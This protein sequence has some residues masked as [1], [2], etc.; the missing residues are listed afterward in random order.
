MADR[1][2]RAL[3]RLLPRE[4]RDAYARDMEVT[5]RRERIDAGAQWTRL[6]RLWLATIAD[7]ARSAPGHH[8]DLLR[9]DVRIAWRMLIARPLHLVAAAGALALGVGA[10]VAMFA[11]VDAVLLRPLPY[12]DAH[13]LLIVQETSRGGEPSNLGYL[14]FTDLKDRARTVRHLSAATQS[15]GTLTGPEADPERVPIM[16]ASAS[17]FDLVGAR[18][19]IGR[20]FT[21]AEDKPGAARRVAILSDRLWR[22][23]FNADPDIINRTI[24]ISGT[25]F[26]VVGVLPADFDDLVAARLYQEAEMWTPL[27]YDPAASFA[28]R[29]CRHLRVFARLDSQATPETAARELS[30]IISASAAANPTQY[31]RPGIV[32]TTLNEFFLGPV[33]P[34]L[35]I[36][37]GGV[38]LLLLVACG[39]VAN[40]LLIRATER[41]AEMAVRTALGVTPGRLFRQLLT[42]SWLL[43]LIGV[44]AGLPL[45]V[46]AIEF[47]VSSAPPQFPRLA[48]ASLDWRAAGVAAVLALATGALFG[49]VPAFQLSRPRLFSHLRDGG[50]RTAGVGTWRVRAAL[51]AGNMAMASALVASGGLVARSVM[52]L[53]AVDTGIR[54]DGVVTARIA[55]SGAHYSAGE[56][57]EQ[58]AK[59][60]AFYDAVLARV[61][62][63]PGVTNAAGVT[64]LPL[65]GSLD[66]YGLHIVGQELP[67]PEAAP[68]AHRFV[69]TPGFFETLQIPAVRGRLLTGDDRQNAPPVAVV[70]ETLARELFP[71][72]DAI[73]RQV[74]LGGADSP[75]RT[76][77]GIAA[78]IRHLGLDVPGGYQVYVPQAQWAWAETLIALVVRTDRDVTAAGG[79]IRDIV[80]QIDPAQPVTGIRAYS[81]IVR[82][83]TSAR[84]LAAA[85]LAGFAGVATLLAAIG[86]YGALGVVVGQRT[87]EIGLRLALGADARRIGALLMAQGL[88]P[89]LVGLAAGLAI[90]AM[91]GGVLRSLLYD[92][93]PVD[94][95]T[96]AVAALALAVCAAIAC[97]IPAWRATRVNPVTA[98]RSET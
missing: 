86:L 39:N 50:R 79:A 68:S 77:V 51:V 47:V 67:N 81:D 97:A 8:W 23:R 45:A 92:I 33:R 63:V 64:T 40:L 91:A 76:I 78:D 36:L 70:S 52:S 93:D 41:S 75:A 7:I 10:A 1:F 5:F 30:G 42:E 83:L 43:A 59:A 56:T 15:I 35:W 27:G 18:A 53:L 73:G 58:I 72:G 62:A 26:T 44:A 11:V 65:G 6:A 48:N 96:L 85:L 25:P 94:P 84:R 55:L 20:T 31:D 80:R 14:T 89:A 29:T 16:R 38:V 12:R 82:D 9:R 90:V 46:W 28:C 69:V 21:E 88:R 49:V 87:P 74:R 13:E 71:K 17:Y 24:Q 19:A 95:A 37:T 60:V 34:V 98:L 57:A 22:R 3:L 4:V 32:T 66:S 54:T 2:F 61:R